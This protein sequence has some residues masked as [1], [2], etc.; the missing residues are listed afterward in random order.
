[1]H[2]IAVVGAGLIGRQHLAR[3]L[4]HPRVGRVRVFDP[5]LTPGTSPSGELAGAEVV[6]SVDDALGADGVIV[7]T[8][9]HTHADLTIRAIGVGTPVL[10]EKPLADSPEQAARVVSAAR[11]SGVPVL[12]G[13]HRRHSAAVAAARRVI[14]SG[15]LGD[16]V[17]VTGTALF[18]KPAHYF[19]EAPWRRAA[20]GGPM[21]INLVHDLD[22][23]RYLVGDVVRLRC[24]ASHTARGFE[25]EDTAALVLEFASGALGT[26]IL[27]DAVA[28]HL[29]WEQTSG[30]NPSYE[31]AADQACYH[32]AGRLGSLSVPTLRRSVAVGEPSW[33]GRSEIEHVPVEPVDPLSAQLDHF[34]DVVQGATPLVT[35]DDGLQAMQLVGAA[36]ASAAAGGRVI[37]I[38]HPA[39]APASVAP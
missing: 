6:G 2:D 11:A 10:V 7:A 20:G 19:V 9:N 27:S 33:W 35:A 37:D 16:V 24:V 28:S 26:F 38:P 17:A 3:L 39:D 4:A 32:V 34:L 23:L 13:H 14:A 18:A 12:V 22:V 25:V 21:L 29:S 1:M 5:A 30:E 31:R 8:P 15:E 36:H